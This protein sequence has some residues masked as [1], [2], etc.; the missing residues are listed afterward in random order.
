M[1]SRCAAVWLVVTTQSIGVA[2]D[3]MG[4]E[5]ASFNDRLGIL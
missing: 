5:E 3:G 1:N 2:L 4:V